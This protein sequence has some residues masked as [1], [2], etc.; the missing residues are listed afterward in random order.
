RTTRV[1]DLPERPTRL[2]LHEGDTLVLTRDP[3]PGAPAVGSRPARISCTL[4]EAFADVRAG[5][6]IC[7]DDGRIGGVVRQATSDHLALA[8]TH[9]PPGG[10]WLGADKGINLPDSDLRLPALTAADL[11]DLKFVA[12][13]ADVVGYSFV[14]SA[15]DVE[16]LHARLEELGRSDLVVILKIETRRGFDHLPEILLA[17]VRGPTVGV[18]IARGDLA[19]ECGFERLPGVPGG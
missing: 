3:A 16:A 6:A 13:H 15:D 11:E 2:R 8:I 12:A 10:A 14:H 17:A 4:P 9:T 1:G 5:E 18:L 19:V 7:L